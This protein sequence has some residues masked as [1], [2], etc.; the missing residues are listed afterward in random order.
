M[1]HKGCI[2]IFSR[3]SSDTLLIRFADM[4]LGHGFWGNTLSIHFQYTFNTH[5]TSV[6]YLYLDSI[7][8]D[9]EGLEITQVG[10]T[11]RGYSARF[12]N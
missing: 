3:Y 12:D 4:L 1:L 7:D 10:C 8:F 9:S 11:T 5:R 2:K 6:P